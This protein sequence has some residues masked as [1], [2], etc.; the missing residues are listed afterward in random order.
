MKNI[1]LVE[2]KLAALGVLLIL[3]HES[4]INQFQILLFIYKLL[5]FAIL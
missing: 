2:Y 1:A 3:I 5:S 4:E